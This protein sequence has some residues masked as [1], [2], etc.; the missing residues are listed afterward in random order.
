MIWEPIRFQYS[1]YTRLMWK[2]E[3]SSAHIHILNMDL[4]VF[5]AVVSQQNIN[6]H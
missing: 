4:R 2:F 3:A 6:M 5:T 1:A